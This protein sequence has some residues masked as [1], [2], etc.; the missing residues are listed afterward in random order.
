[1]ENGEI[2]YIAPPEFHDSRYGGPN[3]ELCYWRH[4]FH[5]IAERVS[6]AG[7]T[8]KLVEIRIPACLQEPTYVI[9]ACKKLRHGDSH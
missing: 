9:Y 5:D 3:S 8:T 7:F 6:I 2:K 4:S 1:M